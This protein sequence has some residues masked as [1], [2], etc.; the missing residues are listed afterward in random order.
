MDYYHANPIKYKPDD[1]IANN[2]LVLWEND[3]IKNIDVV[4]K[5]IIEFL[6]EASKNKIYKKI[7]SS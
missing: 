7:K 6:N 2:V 5:H 4:K 1:I 3:I